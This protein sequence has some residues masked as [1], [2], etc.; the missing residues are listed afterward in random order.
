MSH[1]G[2]FITLAVPT[3]VIL[4]HMHIQYRN[5]LDITRYILYNSDYNIYIESFRVG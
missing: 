3:Y 5:T 2:Y 1:S 4:L